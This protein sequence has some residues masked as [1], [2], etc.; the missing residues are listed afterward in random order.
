VTVS[1]GLC[2]LVSSLVSS[3]P[4]LASASAQPP[5]AIFYRPAHYPGMSLS[6][7]HFRTPAVSDDPCWGNLVGHGPVIFRAAALYGATTLRN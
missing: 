7:A 3:H 2:Q 1:Q 5:L 4:S 6:A